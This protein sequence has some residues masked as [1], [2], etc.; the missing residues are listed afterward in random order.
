[1]A[2][3]LFSLLAQAEPMLKG[4]SAEEFASRQ[5][6]LLKEKISLPQELINNIAIINLTYANEI[7]LLC[8][9]DKTY[10]EIKKAFYSLVDRKKAEIS[11][12]LPEEHK[13]FYNNLE[14]KFKQN[15][16]NEIKKYLKKRA[17]K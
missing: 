6:D 4:L 7:Y 16:W 12:L 14:D 17:V 15:T 13:E 9:A 10:P 5:T 11:N 2:F 8:D 3:F 1:M